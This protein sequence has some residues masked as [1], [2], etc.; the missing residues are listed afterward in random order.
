MLSVVD[1]L[2]RQAHDL[3]RSAMAHQVYHEVS[4]ARTRLEASDGEGYFGTEVAAQ[5]ADILRGY[6]RNEYTEEGFT[7][8]GWPAVPLY[9]PVGA[10]LGD[11]VHG[12]SSTRLPIVGS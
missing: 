8:G 11:G 9:V 1:A 5:A 10:K 3:L 7:D 4:K 12:F 2:P 6:A